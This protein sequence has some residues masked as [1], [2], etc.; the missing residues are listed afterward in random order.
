MTDKY[1]PAMQREALLRFRDAL[2]CR[3]NALRRD[4]CG[5][6]RINGKQGWIYA[7]PEGFQI[8]FFARCGVN[9]FDGV[10]PHIEDYVRA[11]RGLVF[12]RLAQDG[13][14][15]GIFFFDRLPTA[16]EAEVI[17]D[18]LVISKKREMGEPSEAQL[19][20]RKAFAERQRVGVAAGANLLTNNEA[21]IQ[22]KD[23]APPAS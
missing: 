11:K 10:G 23:D 13:T 7:V 21:E 22:S 2:G 4:E 5:D 18:T 6:W 8:C 3:D 14:G 17:R 15:E 12:C 9:E 1:P 20:A 19:A 16:A